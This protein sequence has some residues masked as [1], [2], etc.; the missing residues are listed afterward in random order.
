M[1][2]AFVAAILSPFLALAQPA[3]EAPALPEDQLSV[4]TE[5]ET[6]SDFEAPRMQGALKGTVETLPA[7]RTPESVV[8]EV[9]LQQSRLTRLYKMYRVREAEGIPTRFYGLTLSIRSS[10]EVEKVIVKGP[11]NEEFIKEIQAIVSTWSFS[12]VMEGKPYVA[13][14]KNLDFTFRRNLVLE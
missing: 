10:G 5:I 12:K 2:I 7:A 14:L 3:Q 8:E 13:N 4:S 1:R 11:T 6:S 9:Q